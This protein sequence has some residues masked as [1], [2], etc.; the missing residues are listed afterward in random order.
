GAA[1]LAAL[2]ATA[3]F[4]AASSGVYIINDLRDRESDRRNPR[5]ARGP[6]ASGDLPTGAALAGCVAALAAGG[7]VAWRLGAPCAGVLA[8][9]LGINL[10]Y[11]FRLKHAVLVD[12]MVIALGFV[13]R[14]LAGVFAVHARPTAWIVLCIFFLALF[15]GLG[16]R[17][18]ELAALRGRAAAHR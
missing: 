8:L 12:V 10:A 13:L 9:Y 6:I 5:K 3:M 11:T 16:K 14:V 2:A 17:R 1:Q 4:C 15:L 18:A 7:L